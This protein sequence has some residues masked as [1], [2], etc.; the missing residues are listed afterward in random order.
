MGSDAEWYRV[1]V[2]RSHEICPI[3]WSGNAVLKSKEM[4]RLLYNNAA[5]DPGTEVT[6]VENFCI[7]PVISNG[8]RPAV[9]SC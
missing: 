2:Q 5:P 9:W 1:T 4:A 7:I 3:K 6:E 8:V